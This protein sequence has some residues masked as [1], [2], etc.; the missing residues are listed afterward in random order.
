MAYL[1]TTKK[2]KSGEVRNMAAPGITVQEYLME[3]KKKILEELQTCLET[4]ITAIRQEF[5]AGKTEL[6]DEIKRMC[7]EDQENQPKEED[8]ESCDGESSSE[9]AV[10]MEKKEGSTRKIVITIEGDGPYSGLTFPFKLS[11]R[12]TIMIGRSSG[13]RFR[14]G[15]GIS[16]PKD[17]EVS[18]THAKIFYVKGDMCFSDLSST[19]GSF[20]NDE[21]LDS[22]VLYV[23]SDGDKIRVGKCILK[24]AYEDV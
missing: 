8:N 23:V 9:K 19:N 15:V 6:E 2:R 24:C 11:K 17:D 18:T 3:E 12:L 14:K 20:L 7:E 1:Q 16:L 22:R 5:E 13:K 4:N 21:P 10:T